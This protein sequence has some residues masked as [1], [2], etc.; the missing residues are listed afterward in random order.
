M[1]K[2][3]EKIT[4]FFYHPDFSDYDFG[5]GHPFRGE[6]F[7]AF[8]KQLQERFPKVYHMLDIREPEEAEDEDIL[9]AH[10]REYL[11]R[12]TVLEKKRGWLTIDTQLLPGSIHAARLLAGSSIAAV[13]EALK[14]GLTLGFGGLHHAGL[15]FGGGF[16]ILNDVAIAAHTLLSD[17]T[18]RILILDTDA[19]HGNGTMD[20]FYRDPRVLFI[21]LHQDPRTLF[22][23]VGFPSEIGEKEGIGYTV[24]IPLPPLANKLQYDMA[25]NEIVCP[26]IDEFEPQII[27]RNGGSD[28]L[29]TDTLTNLGLD[30]DS[31]SKLHRRIAELASKNKI[32][33][34]DLFLSGYGPYITEGWLAILRGILNVPMEL[35][36][37]EQSRFISPDKLRV[38]SSQTSE[39]IDELKILLSK[40]W[41]NLS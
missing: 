22:P 10:R 41:K 21:S 12:V 27:I 37:M 18:E 3:T 29:Y 4:P 33:L 15:N 19:H 7:S 13:K 25:F 8:F 39:T 14:S 32:P 16:C 40:Y 35:E 6:R 20:I 28:P 24:N 2:N 38:M 11:E 30:L 5:P 34:A 1:N 23:G 17:G 36:S 26:L 31:L 9:L